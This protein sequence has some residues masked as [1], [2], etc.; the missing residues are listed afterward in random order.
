MIDGTDFNYHFEFVEKNWDYLTFKLVWD[1]PAMTGQETMRLT[2]FITMLDP[3]YISYTEFNHFR[4]IWEITTTEYQEWEFRF[5]NLNN[6]LE[7]P[8]SH[9]L[10]IMVRGKG[11]QTYTPELFAL[12]LVANQRERW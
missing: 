8:K 9:S 10:Q 2:E 1:L 3:H 5:H 11:N 12:D 4:K 7:L 6:K